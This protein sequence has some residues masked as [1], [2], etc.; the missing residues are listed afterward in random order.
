MNTSFAVSKAVEHCFL[1][2]VQGSEP[3]SFLSHFLDTRSLK[4]GVRVLRDGELGLLKTEKRLGLKC[5]P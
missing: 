3:V 2:T 1:P 4:I 5:I